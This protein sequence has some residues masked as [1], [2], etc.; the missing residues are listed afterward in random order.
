MQ[1]IQ[2]LFAAGLIMFLFGGLFIVN[3]VRSL[4]THEEFR[5]EISPEHGGNEDI[6]LYLSQDQVVSVFY[7][8]E[9]TSEPQKVWP[10]IFYNYPTKLLIET[11]ANYVDLQT[12]NFTL[13]WQN[14]SYL[15]IFI[16]KFVI[17]IFNLG[18]DI[19]KVNFTVNTH[20]NPTL[21]VGIGLLVTSSFPLFVIVIVSRRHQSG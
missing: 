2:K 12:M 21:M 3:P 7:R 18:E 11:V 19:I 9:N 6:P 8:F 13:G 20:G 15:N 10:L 17:R 16:I 5:L 4:M 14:A 1:V